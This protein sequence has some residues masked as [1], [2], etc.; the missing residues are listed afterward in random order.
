MCALQSAFPCLKDRFDYEERGETGD[1]LDLVPRL[2]NLISNMVG[3]RQIRN[4]F[5]KNSEKAQ[6]Y[7]FIKL[8]TISTTNT[9]L[10]KM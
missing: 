3:I 9:K 10:F 2:N 7:I 1:I 8:I 6:D 4:S 5:K